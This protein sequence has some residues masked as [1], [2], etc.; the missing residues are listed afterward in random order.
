M[1]MNARSFSRGGVVKMKGDE[2]STMQDLKML[3]YAS[4]YR[5]LISQA[6]QFVLAL[7]HVRSHSV[8]TGRR[9]STKKEPSRGLK[10]ASQVKRWREQCVFLVF[11]HLLV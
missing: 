1:I 3:L 11:P 9:A 5:L 8:L 2:A 4:I 10:D 7:C 6:R